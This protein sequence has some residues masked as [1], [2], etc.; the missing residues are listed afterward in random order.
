MSSTFIS[1]GGPDEEFAKK[2]NSDLTKYGVNTFFFPLDA[3]FGEKLHSTMHRINDYDRTILVCSKDSLDRPGLLYELEKTIEREV[4]E[5]GKSFLIP[6][7][8]DDYVF[9]EWKPEREHLRS[10]ILNRVVAD[11]TGKENYEKQLHR[12]LQSLDKL[13]SKHR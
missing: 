8:L 11:F 5:G 4:R 1:Y 13:K 10:E 6:I 12:L 7:A 3:N 2:L 9:S